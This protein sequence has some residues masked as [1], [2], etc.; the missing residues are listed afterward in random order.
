MSNLKLL[1]VNHYR[2]GFLTSSMI[3]NDIKSIKKLNNAFVKLKKTEKQ[4]YVDEIRNILKTLNNNIKISEIDLIFKENIDE[5]HHD[6]L[7]KYIKEV[8]RDEIFIY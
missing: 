7:K 5:I 4:I 6:V 3:D 1:L 2:N 8:L